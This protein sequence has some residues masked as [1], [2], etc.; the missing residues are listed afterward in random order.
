MVHQHHAASTSSRGP[1]ENDLLIWNIFIK[2]FMKFMKYFSLNVDL[3]YLYQ[4]GSWLPVS[5]SSCLGTGNQKYHEQYEY[6]F[7]TSSTC[8]TPNLP[9]VIS[10]SPMWAS[11]QQ[12]IS[13]WNKNIWQTISP[14]AVSHKHEVSVFPARASH[15][16][17]ALTRTVG[18]LT[19][20]VR[21]AHQVSV[22]WSSWSD[23]KTKTSIL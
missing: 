6:L 16:E 11:L 1:S 4:P 22:A 23:Y 19:L 8:W 7:A 15:L 2:I 5:P 21:G 18:L 13:G 3:F 17:D 10:M 9:V 20:P 12:N 14:G